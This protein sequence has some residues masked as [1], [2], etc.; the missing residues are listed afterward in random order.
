MVKLHVK[1]SLQNTSADLFVVRMKSHDLSP[2]VI[3]DSDVEKKHLFSLPLIKSQ[4]F[5]QVK[6]RRSTE[7]HSSTNCSRSSS[8]FQVRISF[9]CCKVIT[10]GFSDCDKGFEKSR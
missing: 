1:I 5:F 4:L 10:C 7:S 8:R 9:Y 3:K 2:L 6:P